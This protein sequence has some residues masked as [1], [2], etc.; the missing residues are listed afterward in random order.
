LK[1]DQSFIN[2]LN[3]SPK[4]ELI[5]SGIIKLAHSLNMKVIAEGVESNQ[6]LSYLREQGCDGVQGYLIS[7]PVSADEFIERVWLSTK[8]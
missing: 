8:N 6:Q 5:I 3:M 4:D 7:K 2:N 1:M